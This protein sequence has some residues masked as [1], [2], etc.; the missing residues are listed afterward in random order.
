M[1][2][3]TFVHPWH[4]SHCQYVQTVVFPPVKPKSKHL[5]QHVAGVG[6][7]CC[8]RSHSKPCLQSTF[9][10]VAG[11]GPKVDNEGKRRALRLRLDV[12]L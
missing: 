2:P 11:W 6:W 5:Q 1:M 4:L 10:N 3:G 8:S 9:Q 7:P 12:Q